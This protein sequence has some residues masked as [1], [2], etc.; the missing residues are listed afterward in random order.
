[1]RWAVVALVVTAF[2][3]P[4]RASEQYVCVASASTGF[5]WSGTSWDTTQFRP[6]TYVIVNHGKTSNDSSTEGHVANLGD[7]Y[8]SMFCP[9][10]SSDEVR[11]RGLVGQ[12]ILNRNTLRFLYV[13][14]FGYFD[15]VDDRGNTPSIAIGKCSKI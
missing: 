8:P 7:K 13:Y 15:G 3:H 9:S 1:M 6:K 4:A 12:F 14:D 10:F 2:V 11:C 5:K